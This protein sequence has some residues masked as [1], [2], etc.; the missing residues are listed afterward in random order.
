MVKKSLEIHGND[1][2]LR[3]FPTLDDFKQQYPNLVG[4]DGTYDRQTVVEVFRQWFLSGQSACLFARDMAKRPTAPLNDWVAS[5]VSAPISDGA[6]RKML[7]QTVE[8]HPKASQITF[9][10]VQ[11]AEGVAELLGQITRQEGWYAVKLGEV[12]GVTLIGLRWSGVAEGHVT[13]V[14]GFAPLPSMPVTRRAPFTAIILRA[15]PDYGEI[16]R[17]TERG[18]TIVHLADYCVREGG[19]KWD[20]TREMRRALVEESRNQWAKAKVA[21]ALPSAAVGDLKL[22]TL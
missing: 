14:L 15:V 11:T 9:P 3:T 10:Y 4:A 22:E 17:K 13:W 12:D 6:M 1:G 21:F 16:E 7:A 20:K 19:P 2:Q 18:R 8:L 5:C